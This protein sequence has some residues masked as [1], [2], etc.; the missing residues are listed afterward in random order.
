MH[1]ENDQRDLRELASQILDQFQSR[2]V[3]EGNINKRDIGLRLADVIHDR[4][5]ARIAS[6]RATRD[7]IQRAL[8]SDTDLTANERMVIDYKD[9]PF[10]CHHSRKL[11]TDR[12]KS[13][14]IATRNL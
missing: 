14:I 4:L 6:Y 5:D 9:A 13:K 10:A 7:L 2:F 12:E 8:L 11:R 3:F 1:G